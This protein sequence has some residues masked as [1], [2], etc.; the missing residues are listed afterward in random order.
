[1]RQSHSTAHLKIGQVVKVL[2][3]REKYAYAIVVRIQDERTVYIADGNKRKMDNPKKKNV[4]HLEAQPFVGEQVALS[5]QQ[6]QKCTNG[7][8]R[9]ALMQ[10]VDSLPV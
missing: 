1:M 6:T 2:R 10:F 9:I 3:G 7:K 8:L 4:L 5:L